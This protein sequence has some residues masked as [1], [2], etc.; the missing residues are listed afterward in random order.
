MR[1]FFFFLELV[2]ER[3]ARFFTDK[4]WGRLLSIQLPFLQ[5]LGANFNPPFV[6]TIFVSPLS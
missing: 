2:V 3:N 1:F 5:Y 4:V 6:I